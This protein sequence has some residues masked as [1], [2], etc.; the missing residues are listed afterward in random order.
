MGVSE[1]QLKRLAAPMEYKYRLQS[2]KYNKATIVSYIDARA[3]YDRLDEVCGMGN[4]KNNF[5]LIDDKLFCELSI[6]VQRS[7]DQNLA[8]WVSK[9]DT[10]TE[11]QMEK[12]KSQVSDALK[13]SAVLW[14]VG[15]FLYSLGIITLKTAKHTNDKEY[16]CTYDNKILWSV[17]DITEYCK[18]LVAEGRLD[19]TKPRTGGNKVEE[20]KK[21]ASKAQPKKEEVK[22]PEE[23]IRKAKALELFKAHV[24]KEGLKDI[25]L[26]RFAL[27][28]LKSPTIED[29]I[30]ANTIDVIVAKYQELVPPQSTETK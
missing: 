1:E 26:T 11:N 3:V 30:K 17:D 25:Q 9:C 28:K 5:F 19:D 12:E 29:F 23:D 14:G 13:R 2:A 4:W 6:L 10:G 24:E 15:R 27:E 20:P 18:K 16:P 22:A 8:E 21:A 7:E